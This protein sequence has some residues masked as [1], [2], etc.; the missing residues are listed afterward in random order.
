MLFLASLPIISNTNK[1]C[2]SIKLVYE[3][4]VLKEIMLIATLEEIPKVKKKST[5]S[6]S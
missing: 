1:T 3:L 4:S 5:L 6:L 2:S